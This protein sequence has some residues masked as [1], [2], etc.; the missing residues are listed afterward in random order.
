MWIFFNELS[1]KMIKFAVIN[2]RPMTDQEIIQ[3]LIM[4]DNRVTQ[5]FFFV[6]CRPLLTAVVRLVFDYPVDYDEMVNA[7]YEYL[8]A[9]EC[10][11]LRQFQYRSS[12][13]QW[14][15]VVAIRFYMHHRREMIENESKEPPYYERGLEK[16]EDSATEIS[17]RLDVERLLEMMEN[18]RNAL[19]I[20]RLIIDDADPKEFAA[21]IGVTVD[22][23]Y[24][25]K[26]RAISEFTQI[27]LKYYNYG[28]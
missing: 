23:L 11:K 15:K 25:I 28:R 4:R 12:L 22:N 20:R 18:K 26:R 13:Y 21:E 3:G 24:N 10:A 14:L 9:D 2:D 7:L 16:S 1:K 5:Q 19:T 17:G 6:K 8:M 27:A